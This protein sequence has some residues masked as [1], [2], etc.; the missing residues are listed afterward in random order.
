[1]NKIASDETKEI[2]ADALANT[3]MER[4]RELQEFFAVPQN[5]LKY[6]FP[7]PESAYGWQNMGRGQATGGQI[8]KS[9]F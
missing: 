9:P 5:R 8:N 4:V 3:P 1:M 2:P 6:Q 7:I